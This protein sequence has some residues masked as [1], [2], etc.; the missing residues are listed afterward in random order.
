MRVFTPELYVYIS[1]SDYIFLVA[2]KDENE[3]FEIIYDNI[4]PL[5][6][7]STNATD[8]QTITSIVKK[9]LFQIEQKINFLFKEIIII[10]NNSN[11][12]FVSLSGFKKLNGSQI[13]KENISYIINLS[14][15]NLEKN[16]S[17]KK[18]IHIFNA[19]SYLD[20]KKFE[21]LPIGLFGDFYSHEL[22]F[23]L[24]NINDQK[25]FHSIFNK[26]NLKIKK[27]I[28]LNYLK[29]SYISEQDQNLKSF[30][31]T[32][33]NDKSSEIFFFEDGTLIFEQ[34]FDFGTNL[35]LQDISKVT[36]LKFEKVKKILENLNFSKN[37]FK[38]EL[39]ERDFFI[40]E[41]YR[42][43]KKKLLYD[44]AQARIDEFSE[45]IITKNINLKSF[46]KKDQMILLNIN[47][48]NNYDY[49]KEAYN[50]SFSNN[51]YFKLNFTEDISN[52]KLIE[53]ANKIVHFG[54]KKE[55]VPVVDSQ[56]S[57][58]KRLFDTIF[59]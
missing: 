55:A 34:K 54:W 45:L 19:K 58:M 26:C 5:N 20:K 22:T 13:Q 7:G 41:N 42:K 33:I 50:L 16:E 17:S 21:N 51:N 46:L 56:K 8:L 6:I 37:N 36:S 57:V 18:I 30:L 4:V 23:C 49:F 25:N 31:F 44:V 38:D 47:Y 1:D 27:F 40:D 59:S 29:G 24:S 3:N 11:S 48:L 39:I 10:L 2:N 9:N 12:S 52:K 28:L 43:I 35:V 53:Q 32:K 15:T 14:K